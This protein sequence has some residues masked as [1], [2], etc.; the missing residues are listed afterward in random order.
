MKVILQ[1]RTLPPAPKPAEE[2]ELSAPRT[3]ILGRGCFPL[4]DNAREF[5]EGWSPEL[6]AYA[7]EALVAPARTLKWLAAAVCAKQ[8]FLPSVTDRVVAIEGGEFGWL[9]DEDR[10]TIRRAWRAPLLELRHQ[11]LAAAARA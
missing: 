9:T 5:S 7:P 4:A 11:G 1:W 8:V 3:A 2:G 6:L 10:E